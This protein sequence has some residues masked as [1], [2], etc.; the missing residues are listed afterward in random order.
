MSNRLRGFKWFWQRATRGWADCDT[1]SVDYYLNEVIVGMVKHLIEHQAGVP[2][3]LTEEK[4]KNILSKIVAGFEANAKLLDGR[5]TNDELESLQ[6]K[7]KE[8]FR[9]FVKYYNNLWS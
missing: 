8:G 2:G 3:N 5:F 4:W 9:L 1:W 6:K 7:N